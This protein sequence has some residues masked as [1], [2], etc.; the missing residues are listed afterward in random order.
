M[1]I[2]GHYTL[3]PGILKIQ[4]TSVLAYIRFYVVNAFLIGTLTLDTAL[5]GSA[6]MIAN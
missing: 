2:I 6:A 4:K 3:A 5:L 1:N